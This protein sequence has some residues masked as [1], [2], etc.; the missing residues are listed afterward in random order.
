MDKVRR[1]PIRFGVFE[2]DLQSGE[3]RKRGVKLKL[4]EQPFQALTML[5]ERPNEVVTRD[6]MQRS[7]WPEG[8]FVDFDRGLN[9]AINRL[10]DVLGDDADSPRFIETLPQRGYRFIAP[11]EL[12][13]FGLMAA[14]SVEPPHGASWRRRWLLIAMGML[15]LVACPLA[16]NLGGIRDRFLTPSAQSRIQSL[17]V[18]PL[19]NL[20]GDPTQEYFADGITD[21]MI[22]EIAKIASLRVISRTSVMP[23]KASRKPLQVIAKELG[24]DA[25]LEGTV[26]HAGQKVRITAQLIQARDDRHLWSEKYDRDLKDI[27]AIQGEVAQA[28]AGQVRAK[29]TPEQRADFARSRPVNPQAYEAYLEGSF[30]RASSPQG[31][32]KSVAL[33]TKAIEIDPAYAQG[34][35]G[36]A[37]SYCALGIFG[38]RPSAEAYSK[39]KSAVRKALELDELSAEAHNALADIRKGYDWDWVGAEAEYKRALELNP[40]YAFARRWYAEFLSKMGRHEEAISEARRAREDDPVSGGNTVLAMVLYRARKYD[41]AQAVCRKVLELHADHATAL[42][43]LAL[44]HEQQGKLPEAIAELEKAMS[45]SGGAPLYRALLGN[46]YGLSGKR[47]KALDTLDDLKT[48]SKRTYVSPLD[49]AVVHTGLGDRDSAFQWLEQAYRERAMRIQELNSPMFDSLRP[50]P[51]FEDLIRRIGLPR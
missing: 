20:S 21:E 36:L 18:L 22:T 42:W 46:A 4:P 3:L 49:F 15:L 33:F 2:V 50:D 34:Y 30:L 13:V 17:A 12:A 14:P 45:A 11:V 44:S 41:E 32:E 40:S 27:L 43:F 9:K 47:A 23:Y 28:V 5:L 10:R 16:L 8:T 35:A 51:R 29:L 39:A 38:L 24:V 1:T 26:L 25:V 19:E 6:E 31:L 7:L 48:L 37:T